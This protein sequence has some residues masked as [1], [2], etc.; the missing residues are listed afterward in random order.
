MYLSSQP[1][2]GYVVWYTAVAF[3]IVPVHLGLSSPTLVKYPVT[4]DLNF[5]RLIFEERPERRKL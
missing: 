4:N 5:D 1:V 3:G 2:F